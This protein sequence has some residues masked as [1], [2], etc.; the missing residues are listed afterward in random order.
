MEPR[1][2]VLRHNQAEGISSA[3]PAETDRGRAY[4]G[5]LE[6]QRRASVATQGTKVQGLHIGGANRERRALPTI[7]H[8][9]CRGV[10]LQRHNDPAPRP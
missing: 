6:V 3:L 9:Q 7:V 5:P 10:G 1:P 8:T 4:H 2:H